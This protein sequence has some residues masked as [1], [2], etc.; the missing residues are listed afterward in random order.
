LKAGL[1]VPN[2]DFF[3]RVGLVLTFEVT[4]VLKII[5]GMW[6]NIEIGVMLYGK[7]GMG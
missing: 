5:L 7:I 3:K 1:S 4:G 2:W 6:G